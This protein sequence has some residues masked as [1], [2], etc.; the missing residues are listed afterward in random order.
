[1]VSVGFVLPGEF[2]FGKDGLSSVRVPGF[3]HVTAPLAAAAT[4]AVVGAV[5]MYT[6]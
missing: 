3:A 2:V 4:A 5:L 1:M 6:Q